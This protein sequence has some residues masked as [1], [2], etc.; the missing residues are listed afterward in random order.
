MLHPLIGAVAQ[1][2]TA[3]LRRQAI[4]CR[5]AEAAART[6]GPRAT[7]PR[8][9]GARTRSRLGFLLIET[10]LHLMSEPAAGTPE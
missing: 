4:A 1:G 5:A 6:R 10:G 8:A 7:G 9:I 2:R 3:E